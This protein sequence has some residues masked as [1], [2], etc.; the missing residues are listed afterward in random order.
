M[1]SFSKSPV[2]LTFSPTGHPLRAAL[3]EGRR[4]CCCAHRAPLQHFV[5]VRGPRDLCFSVFVSFWFTRYFGCCGER[6]LIE[7]LFWFTRYPFYNDERV[8]IEGIFWYTRYS[9]YCDERVLIECLFEV[10]IH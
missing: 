2:P 7:V 8:S 3:R 6:I 1:L 5:E 10:L 4:H 9:L